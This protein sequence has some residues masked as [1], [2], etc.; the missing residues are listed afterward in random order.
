MTKTSKLLCYIGSTLLLLMG[1]FHGS[2]LGY[3]TA[4]IKESDASD[5]LKEIVPVLFA[6]PSIHLLGLGA[7]GIMVTIMKQEYNKILIFIAIMIFIDAGLGFY[8]GGPI[9][10]I[11]L[12][13]AG[14][15]FLMAALRKI[16]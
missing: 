8:V 1:L 6:H 14:A 12:S 10:G 4:L 5:L 11:A 3:I 16:R 9:P 7:L 2:G 13:V 15:F